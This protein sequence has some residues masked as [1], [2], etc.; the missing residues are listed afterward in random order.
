MFVDG[1]PPTLAI[2]FSINWSA[3]YISSANLIYGICIFIFGLVAL[4]V[5]QLLAALPVFWWGESESIVD[6]AGFIGAGSGTMI[7]LEGYSRPL[8]F[9]L[10]TIIPV[11][12]ATAF[13]TSAILGKS[14]APLL[15]FWSFAIAALA[16]LLRNVAWK[17]A[18]RNYTSASS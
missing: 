10:G 6:L 3:L 17:I 5:F 18:I 8:Q 15:F 14:N 4:N 13:S 1:F 16:I 2:I 9:I 11:L 12:I 7:P